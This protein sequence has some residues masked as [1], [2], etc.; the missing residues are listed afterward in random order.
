M[1]DQLSTVKNFSVGH[2]IYEYL[3]ASFSV[4]TRNSGNIFLAP[5]GDIL[6]K[7]R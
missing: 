7:Q 3:P 6:R 4:T 1:P 5:E 2:G